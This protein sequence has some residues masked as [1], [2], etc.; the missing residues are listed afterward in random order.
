MATGSIL[1]FADFRVDAPN[2]RL[3]RDDEPLPITPKVLSVLHHLAGRPQQLV[4]KADLF[5]HVWP[6]TVV[7]DAVL[8]VAIGELRK[9]LGDDPRTPRFI[10]TVHR[11]GYRFIAPVKAAGSAAGR[12]ATRASGREPASVAARRDAEPDSKPGIVGRDEEAAL[13]HEAL[14]RTLDGDRQIVF[15]TGAPGLG[16]T[17][18]VD[19]FLEQI[20]ARETVWL[21]KGQCLE[22]YG[23]GEP[24][25][26]VFEA[27]G[28]LAQEV[29]AEEFVPLLRRHA[30]SW[31]AQMPRLLDEDDFV[32][33]LR[34]TAG[35]APERRLREMLDALEVLAAR[36]PLLLVL[37]DLHWSDYSTIDL[38]AALARRRSAAR[39]LVLATF[40]PADVVAQGH[41]LGAV[42]QE[43]VTRRLAR[44][45]PLGLLPRAA[46]G[47]Y[48][49][50]RFPDNRFPAE[51][52]GLLQE[53]T[54]GNPL[55]LVHLLDEWIEGRRITHEDGAWQVGGSLD[56]LGRELPRSLR[57]LIE[58]HV[59]RSKPE[60]QRLVAAAS[61]VGDEFAV[62]PLAAA[63][64][65]DPVEVE[66][67]CE[68]LVARDLLERR[69]IGRDPEGT[70]A[71]LYGFRHALYRTVLYERIPVAQRQQWHRRVARAIEHASATQ[72]SDVAAELAL[73]FE[74]GCEEPS[75]VRYLG[76]AAQS[77]ILRSAHREA[78]GYLRRAI[79]LVPAL[80][81]G[82]ERDRIELVLR[83]AL[84]VA[85]SATQ[86]YAAPEVEETYT[87][88]LE[89]CRRT[90][91]TTEVFSTL[92]GLC[93]FYGV[94]ADFA[95]A[96]EV[97]DQLYRHAQEQ[98]DPAL[99]LE[100][101][102][103]KGTM[104]VYRGELAAA[105]RMLE[106]GASLYRPAEHGSNAHVYGQDPG[107]A[108]LSYLSWVLLVM[109]ELDHAVNRADAA[110]A[111]AGEIGHPFTLAFALHHAALTHQQRDDRAQTQALIAR[112]R[113]LAS[114]QEFPFWASMAQIAHGGE[115]VR[116][117]ALD[118][119]GA[120]VEQGLAIHR[121][122]G[123][124]I[125]STYWL[126]LLAECHARRGARDAALE[127]VERALSLVE[128]G[129]ER[130]WEAELHRLRGDV[131]LGAFTTPAGAADRRTRDQAA[132]CFDRAL[133]VARAQGAR[134][135]ELRA[136]T[137]L[138][139]LTSAA[140]GAKSAIELL[141]PVA[142]AFGEGHDAPDLRAASALLQELHGS[143]EESPRR[144]AR[145]RRR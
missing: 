48:L 99:V 73:H 79:A 125:G 26:P 47:S 133:G 33:L 19:A 127:V 121:A 134:L 86:G 108:C 17:T 24:F 95:V 89:L 65:G 53:R 83:V 109:G 103:A 2:G 50:A 5:A 38:I 34:T 51:L 66:R 124:D 52:P 77:A 45:L 31:L 96:I 139:R 126:G 144:R 54:D 62:G 129:Q 102:W 61:V 37:E 15:V 41:P 16:K 10:E 104:L 78:I 131:L 28:T 90:G 23:A 63:L 84:G 18:L 112:L 60:E 69:G 11:R 21:A 105:R 3:W 93:R 64:D 81:D 49:A 91:G 29:P 119:G 14:A 43:L 72:A 7:G 40:R 128:A 110:L 80:P 9:L 113:E 85:L 67:R 82:E 6:E 117:G 56:D 135:W 145:P 137:R 136:A 22:H 59:A 142:D 140:S 68:D 120:A 70:V 30:P 141:Q 98:D 4:T 106:H 32:T 76:L 101:S 116:D 97:G 94:R 12:A 111:L 36:A 132:V 138:A 39:M 71:Q 46:V 13:L 123:A 75:A 130:L 74:Q 88:A 107:V 118:D 1:A 44:E 92:H 27:L 100:A 55:F 115:L 87:R 8:T 57:A 42:A 114:E 58:Q 143:E 122:L 20:A 35:V 25:L